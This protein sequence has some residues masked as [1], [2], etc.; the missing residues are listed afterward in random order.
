M[1]IHKGMSLVKV[2][3]GIA[4]LVGSLMLFAS[5]I[6]APIQERNEIN[7]KMRGQ[8][9]YERYAA[10]IMHEI[11]LTDNKTAYDLF[12]GRVISATGLVI[13]KTEAPQSARLGPEVNGKFVLCQF[14]PREDDGYKARLDRAVTVR[15]IARITAGNVRLTECIVVQDIRREKQINDATDADRARAE[16]NKVQAPPTTREIQRMRQQQMWNHANRPGQ[17]NG[18]TY[19]RRITQ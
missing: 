4:V 1:D 16:A 17:T 8:P 2:V 6:L 7:A 18:P 11:S 5:W 15:G 12:D 13:T 3:V 9:D 14:D 10:E 19:G